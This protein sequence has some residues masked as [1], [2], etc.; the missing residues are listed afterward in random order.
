MLASELLPEALEE[1]YQDVTDELLERVE[2]EFE[3]VGLSVFA[4]DD[5]PFGAAW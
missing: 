1:R 3:A 5:L 4:W 2:A